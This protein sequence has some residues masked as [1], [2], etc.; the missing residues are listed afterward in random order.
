ME[1]ELFV[2][3]NT[4]VAHHRYT[5]ENQ[6]KLLLEL[7]KDIITTPNESSASPISLRL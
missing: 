2:F 6:E 1:T 4:H 5:K 3:I 7:E